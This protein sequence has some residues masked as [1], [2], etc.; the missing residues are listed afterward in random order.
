MQPTGEQIVQMIRAAG[1]K[2][3]YQSSKEKRWK[4]AL[5]K[6]CDLVAVAGGDGTVSK[7]A[8]QLMDSGTPIA[9]LPMG[10]ANNIAKTLGIADESF[11]T[12]IDGW[13]SARSVKFDA[14]VAKGPWGT[15]YF[16]EGFGVGLFAEAMARIQEKQEAASGASSDPKH[17]S[18]SVLEILKKRL[19]RMQASQL[20]VRLDGEKFSDEYLLF[21]IL[22]VRYLGPNLNLVP[23]ADVGD[24]LFDVVFVSKNERNKLSRYL[25]SLIRGRPAT[26]RLSVRTGKRLQIEWEGSPVHFDDERWPAEGEQ[27]PARLI[28]IDARIKPAAVILLLPRVKQHSSSKKQHASK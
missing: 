19:Q 12:L 18:E 24:G 14:G 27:I 4:K 16:V 21:E 9:L 13:G 3:K 17:D 6:P 23:K 11:A 2:V 10:T 1:H 5:E 20:T 22:N 8:K 25:A 7:V 15:E 28:K 26:S